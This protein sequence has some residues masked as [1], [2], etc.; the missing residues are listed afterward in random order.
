MLFIHSSPARVDHGKPKLEKAIRD[1][2]THSTLEEPG[3]WLDG[4]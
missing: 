4:V 1:L 3:K 2:T